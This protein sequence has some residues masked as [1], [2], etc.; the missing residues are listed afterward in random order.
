ME[1]REDVTWNENMILQT[2]MNQEPD[3]F[4]VA[5]K[6]T[7]VQILGTNRKHLMHALQYS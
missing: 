4:A 5:I 7:K 2:I 6:S 3:S 1:V